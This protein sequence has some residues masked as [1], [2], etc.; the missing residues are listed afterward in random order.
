MRLITSRDHVRGA[1]ASPY[2]FLRNLY[3][4][5]GF[6]RTSSESDGIP[7]RQEVEGLWPLVALEG[8]LHESCGHISGP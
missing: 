3:V 8:A 5:L 6:E 4:E 2:M 1:L 7:W